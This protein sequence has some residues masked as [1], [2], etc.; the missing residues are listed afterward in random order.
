[1]ENLTPEERTSR[2]TLLEAEPTIR[3]A[4]PLAADVEALVRTR[5]VP[6]WTAWLDRAAA[7]SLPEPR[8]FAAGIRRD[9]AAD[10]AALSVIWSNG[11]TEAQLNRLK[12][13]KRQR[14]G[15][16]KLDLLEKRFLD[17]A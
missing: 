15:R 6:G 11:Q 13:L 16:A 3:E 5:D 4:Q 9:R 14:S 10:N 7:R 2:T 1:V 12:G 17:A 8:S